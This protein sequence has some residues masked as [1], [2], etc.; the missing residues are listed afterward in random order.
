MAEILGLNL[1]KMYLHKV[2]HFIDTEIVDWNS[3]KKKNYVIKEYR[4]DESIKN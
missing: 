4:F 1:K 2:Q 3:N